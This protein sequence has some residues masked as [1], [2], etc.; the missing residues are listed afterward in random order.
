MC[1]WR[2]V[3]GQPVSGWVKRVFR[4]WGAHGTFFSKTNGRTGREYYAGHHPR[5]DALFTRQLPIGL[6]MSIAPDQQLLGTPRGGVTILLG[7]T[8]PR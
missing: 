1:H 8:F 3:L 6:L 7:L 4:V 5:K 2:Y